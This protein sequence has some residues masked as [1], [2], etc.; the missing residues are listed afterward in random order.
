M[1]MGWLALTLT[2]AASP[3]VASPLSVVRRASDEVAQIL[4]TG[5]ATAEQL[6]QRSDAFIDYAELT[7]RA[8]GSKWA[9]L[10]KTRRDEFVR[11]MRMLLRAS[12][13]HRALDG[14][15]QKTT[16]E[17]GVEQQRAS[18]AT[19]QST[20]VVKSDRF[21][22]EY[23]MFRSGPRMPW[24]VYDVVTDGVSLV[25][26]YADQ[27]RQALA[28]RSDEDLLKTLKT[29]AEQLERQGT[30]PRSPPGASVTA[31]EAKAR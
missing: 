23:R 11:A 14:G 26:T 31:E 22:V 1:M 7:K 17:W 30:S 20:V 2:Y 25:Q 21:P 24:K 4:D 5:K 16:V 6:A 8:F 9:S 18:E 3:V 10:K 15:G 19:V 13:A 12:Y 28:S 27:F 29:R